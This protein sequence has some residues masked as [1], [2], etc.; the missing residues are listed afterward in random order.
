MVF[1]GKD[2]LVEKM[3]L[4]LSM[5]EPQVQ[6]MRAK[7]VDYYESHLRP[8]VLARSMETRPERNVTVL[9]HTELNMA[10]SASKLNRRSVSING[11]DSHGPLRWIGKTIDRYLFGS[12][13]A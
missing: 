3:C 8:E 5:P 11:L 2:D 1:G 6:A 10:R 7:V 4:A 13:R 12:R 9:L